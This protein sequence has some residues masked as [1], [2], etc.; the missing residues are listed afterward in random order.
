[1]FWWSSDYWRYGERILNRIYPSM[2]ESQKSL[3]SVSKY[4]WFVND[5]TK[6]PEK[7]INWRISKYKTFKNVMLPEETIQGIDSIMGLEVLKTK[8]LKVLNMSELTPLAF[9]IGFEPLKN[10]PMWF[11][12]NVSLFDKEIKEFCDKIAERQYDLVLFEVIPNLNQF[13]PNE[14]RKSLQQH[15]TKVISFQ[16]PRDNV[17]NYIEVYIKPSAN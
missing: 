17:T 3:N 2:N 10:Q 16:A 5:S 12:R 13:N 14:V 8:N 7:K 1:M 15:Y 4:T 11:H 9:E 6:Q